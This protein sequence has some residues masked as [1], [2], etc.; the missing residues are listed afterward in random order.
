[1]NW[2]ISDIPSQKGKVIIVTGA[3]SGLGYE[4]A[5]ALAI[6]DAEVIMS[7]RNIKN[8]E[9]AAEK[10]K[11]ETGKSA[12][13]VMKLDLADLSSVKAFIKE[14]KTRFNR[15]DILINNAGV[16]MPPY[17]KT[18]E[19]FELQMGTNHL[20]HFALTAGLFD[21]LKNTGSTR[22]VNLSSNAHKFGKIDFDD[23]NWEKRKYSSWRAYGDSKIANLYFTYELCRK[24]DKTDSDIIVA[25]AHPGYSATN[26]QRYS[27]IFEFL[28]GFLA[29]SQAM[30]ALNPLYAATAG[31]VARGDYYG[32][33]GWQEWRGYP[34][35]TNS[36]TL[37][38]D[39]KTASY[40]WKLSEELTNTKFDV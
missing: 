29:Q 7:A 4:T 28:N 22:I 2:N 8:G 13:T 11:K 25:A 23:F 17:S 27:G 30:G 12:L 40:L 31:D 6:K 10:I 3:N 37:A 14:F 35:K 38:H 1:M 33:K 39:A 24:L 36:N 32:P 9:S 16:M 15:L 21:L 19:G 34:H 20:G 26:L 18:K 5:K